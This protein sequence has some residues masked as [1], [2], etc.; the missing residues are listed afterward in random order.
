MDD[1]GDQPM[2]VSFTLKASLWVR[3]RRALKIKGDKAPLVLLDA[4]RS[5]IRGVEESAGVGTGTD[6]G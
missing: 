1:S 6:Q 5:Y 4:V 3:W 2:R